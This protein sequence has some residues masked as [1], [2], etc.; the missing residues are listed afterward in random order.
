MLAACFLQTQELIS[1]CTN[2]ILT[3]LSKSTIATYCLHIDTIFGGN[4]RLINVSTNRDYIRLKNLA[5]DTLLPHI[6]SFLC[7][8]INFG[9]VTCLA[10]AQ[11]T[12]SESASTRGITE[13]LFSLL[14]DL[15][16]AWFKCIIESPMLAVPDEFS[17]YQLLKKAA[18]YRW[19]K[20]TTGSATDDGIKRV[21]TIGNK[22]M[23]AFFGSLF[24]AS[25]SSLPS[26]PSASNIKQNL[27]TASIHSTRIPSSLRGSV[28]SFESSVFGS[29]C[30][31]GQSHNHSGPPAPTS[32]L[33]RLV[34]LYGQEY[35]KTNE[36][37][38]FRDEETLVLQMFET[39]IIYTY[40]SFAQLEKVKADRIVSD[41]AVLNSFWMQAELINR[42]TTPFQQIGS[43]GLSNGFP[44]VVGPFRFSVCLKGLYGFVMD[45]LEAVGK[46]EKCVVASEGV[47]CAGIDYR[48]LVAVEVNEKY[49]KKE[50]DDVPPRS[51]I[52]KPPS[53]FQMNRSKSLDDL[54]A[55]KGVHGGGEYGIF[56]GVEDDLVS[57][58]FVLKAT[59]QRNR[60]HGMSGNSGSQQ[61]RSANPT[62]PISYS[63]YLLDPSTFVNGVTLVQ[64]PVTNVR[65]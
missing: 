55:G 9:V 21:S 29:I 33:S 39:G 20:A 43:G 47:K 35:L 17:R 14:S 23:T 22:K 28:A 59:L 56:Q 51:G 13:D 63:I 18:A 16:Q 65:F 50:M 7:H 54:K 10:S 61:Q 64:Q 32:Y 40:M 31:G 57:R 53:L 60:A 15:P 4:S 62:P 38:A 3:T 49:E 37:S 58:K 36:L 5:R 27:D 12:A 2:T 34:N 6:E 30:G 19:R 44:G 25:S 8:T 11:S 48:V 41:T 24:S 45:N 46:G 42:F 52:S 1:F 26:S